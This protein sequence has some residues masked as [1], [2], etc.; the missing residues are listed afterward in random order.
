MRKMHNIAAHAR[1]LP[2]SR[3]CTVLFLSDLRSGKQG[4]WSFC[5]GLRFMR[6]AILGTTCSRPREPFEIDL[7]PNQSS[8]DRQGKARHAKLLVEGRKCCCG[9]FRTCAKNRRTTGTKLQGNLHFGARFR[10]SF[11]GC[12]GRYRGDERVPLCIEVSLPELQVTVR[13]NPAQSTSN[14]LTTS[15]SCT[16]SERVHSRNSWNSGTASDD[17]QLRS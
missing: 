14:Q 6:Y 11:G 2:H 4:H 15:S 8:S 9:I 12:F 13:L 17:P 5:V 7:N 1:S 16:P 3:T 10:P